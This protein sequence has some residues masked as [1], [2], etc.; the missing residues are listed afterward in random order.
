MRTK[1]QFLLADLPI[2][3]AKEN[4]LKKVTAIVIDVPAATVFFQT[5]GKQFFT[6]AGLEMD[7]VAIPPGQADLTPQMSKI[8]SDGDSVAHIIGDDSL[9]I[10]ALNGLKTANFDGPR[11]VLNN[12]VN[13]NVRKAVGATMEGVIEAS[14]SPVGDPDDPGQQLMKA[15]IDTYGEGDIDPGSALTNNMF[16]TMMGARTALDGLK[17]EVTPASII[18]ATKAMP[19]EELPNGGG[20][21]F[22]CNGKAFEL[23]P[24]VCTRGTLRTTLDEEGQPTLPFEI[25]SDTPIP[26]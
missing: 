25:V 15:V 12:C 3:V 11:T 18:A 5:V 10:A 16:M 8:A 7:L 17:G 9:C 14:P 4:K 22:R 19:L 24:A 21:H 20:L 26:D 13:D 6:D 23:T 1:V 2:N